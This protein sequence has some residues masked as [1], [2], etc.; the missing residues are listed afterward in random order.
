[1]FRY[2]AYCIRYLW[3]AGDPTGVADCD[4]SGDPEWWLVG[5][6]DPAPGLFGGDP[7]WAGLPDPA[8]LPTG[9]SEWWLPF[10]LAGDP[11]LSIKHKSI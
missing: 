2:H 5:D 11:W 9:L 1:M 7:L 4:L 3:D 8:G 6:P 10:P